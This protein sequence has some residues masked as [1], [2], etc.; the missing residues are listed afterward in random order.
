MTDESGKAEPPIIRSK[1]WIRIGGTV[2]SIIGTYDNRKFNNCNPI[3]ASQ[4]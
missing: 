1:G 2:I 4:T 3:P